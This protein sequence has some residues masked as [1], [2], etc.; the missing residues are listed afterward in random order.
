MLQQKLNDENYCTE[1]PEN[2]S[3]N[4]LVKKDTHKKIINFS[5]LSKN[6]QDN[7]KKLENKSIIPSETQCISEANFAQGSV[8][9]NYCI[10]TTTQSLIIPPDEEFKMSQKF[11]KML[12]S[13]LIFGYR[14]LTIKWWE[15]IQV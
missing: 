12:K 1:V 2:F 4:T 13:M 6:Y 3:D 10:A 14:V 15:L 7:L 9:Q 11:N 8:V 5:L